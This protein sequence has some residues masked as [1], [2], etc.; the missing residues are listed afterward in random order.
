MRFFFIVFIFVLTAAGCYAAYPFP[1]HF[2]KTITRETEKG[3][4]RKPLH[5]VGK[6][7]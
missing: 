2:S 6:N 7:I 5:R 4:C 3:I 1:F